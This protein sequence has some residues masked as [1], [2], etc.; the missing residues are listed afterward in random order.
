MR[1]KATRS[2]IGSSSK[3]SILG[4]KIG[5]TCRSCET[6]VRKRVHP[7]FI[8]GQV[9]Y[10]SQKRGAELCGEASPPLRSVSIRLHPTDSGIVFTFASAASLY[11][12]SVFIS[13]CWNAM[14]SVSNLI[15]NR[16][17]DSLITDLKQ[18]NYSQCSVNPFTQFI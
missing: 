10:P 8:Q 9:P 5:G 13:L 2:R 6:E 1:D 16:K 3:E 4:Q 17:Y 14:I 12:Y 7:S 18:K 11:S 15:C